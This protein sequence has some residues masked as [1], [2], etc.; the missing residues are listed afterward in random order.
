MSYRG[1]MGIGGD[2]GGNVSG[3]D[4]GVTSWVG[5]MGGIDEVILDI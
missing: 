5:G 4:I 3:G 1:D 2:I